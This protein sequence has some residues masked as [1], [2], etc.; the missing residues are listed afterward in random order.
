MKEGS[1]QVVVVEVKTTIKPLSVYNF[2]P[3]SPALPR[4]AKWN[5]CHRMNSGQG[6]QIKA[7]ACF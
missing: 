6:I 3:L 1:D 4:V 5:G 2:S 7:G